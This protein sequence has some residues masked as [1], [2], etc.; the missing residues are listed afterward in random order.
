MID[1]YNT[2]DEKNALDMIRAATVLA[3]MPLSRTAD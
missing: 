2:P 3:A 1:S